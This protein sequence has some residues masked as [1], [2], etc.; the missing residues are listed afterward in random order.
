MA[1]FSTCTRQ[2]PVNLSMPFRTLMSAL[3]GC[4]F[5]VV[6]PFAWMTKAE[7]VARI[8]ANGFAI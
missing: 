8:A 3:F 5:D 1:H 7:V 4:E 2:V 6:N